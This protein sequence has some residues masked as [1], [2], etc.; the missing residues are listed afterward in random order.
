[1]SR[2]QKMSAKRA[3]SVASGV[4]RNIR[5]GPVLAMAC[6]CPARIRSSC[7]PRTASAVGDLL[8]TGVLHQDDPGARR[9]AGELQRVLQRL[10]A[11]ARV[12]STAWWPIGEPSKGRSVLDDAQCYLSGGLKRPSDMDRRASQNPPALPRWPMSPARRSVLNQWDSV[13][14]GA[15]IPASVGEP[16]QSHTLFPFGIVF[17]SMEMLQISEVRQS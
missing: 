6:N 11:N 8:H 12:I 1:M 5:I 14:T 7:H 4:M 9:H 16:G 2:S 10:V 15:D 3:F 13:T 17:G